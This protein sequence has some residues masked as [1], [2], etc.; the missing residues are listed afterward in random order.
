MNPASNLY[1]ISIPAQTPMFIES[2]KFGKPQA[3]Y[4]KFEELD[5][6]DIYQNKSVIIPLYD[7]GT[8]DELAKEFPWGE[9]KSFPQG[10]IKTEKSFQYFDLSY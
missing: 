9:I 3:T 1:G 7:G 5:K 10:E 2:T 6:I 8:F 4:L